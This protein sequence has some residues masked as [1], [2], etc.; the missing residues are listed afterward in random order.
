MREKLV[1]NKWEYEIHEIENEYGF[2]VDIFKNDI[3]IFSQG[4]FVNINHAIL[5]AKDYFLFMEFD[6]ER[7]NEI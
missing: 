7:D 6:I 2:R 4:G 3:K 5:Y 1:E